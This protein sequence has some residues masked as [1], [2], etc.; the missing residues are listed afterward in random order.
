MAEPKAL[1][2]VEDDR[3][4][5]NLNKRVLTREGYRVLVARN[6]NEAREAVENDNPQ[7]IVLDWELPDG[8][9]F[10]FCRELRKTT[11]IPIVFLTALKGEEYEKAGYDAG[12]NDYITK[13]YHMDRLTASIETL[14]AQV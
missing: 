6:L 3:A 10:D 11:A 8:S 4:L 13:P 1:L 5:V 9:I 12:S 7:A 14:L 2:L